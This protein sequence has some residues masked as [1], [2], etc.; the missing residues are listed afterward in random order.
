[1]DQIHAKDIVESVYDNEIGDDDSEVNDDSD[2]K[3]DAASNDTAIVV[4]NRITC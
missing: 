2:S 3:S 1:V 4:R